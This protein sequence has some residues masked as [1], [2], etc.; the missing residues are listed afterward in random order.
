MRSPHLG[1]LKPY[2][3]ISAALFRYS[4]A[5][6]FGEKSLVAVIVFV[7]CYIRAAVA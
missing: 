5:A 4:I 7:L 6:L 3:W 1:H 2:G